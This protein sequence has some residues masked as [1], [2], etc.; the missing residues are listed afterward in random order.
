MCM[1]VWRSTFFSL[2]SFRMFSRKTKMLNTSWCYCCFLF[3]L[4]QVIIDGENI[5]GKH[6]DCC[7]YHKTIAS[8]Y[9]LDS[10]PVAVWCE[11]VGAFVSVATMTSLA[12][13]MVSL[14]SLWLTL[15]VPL[16]LSNSNAFCTQNHKQPTSDGISSQ[17]SKVLKVHIC[18][19]VNF[20]NVMT[21]LC[22]C[23]QPAECNTRA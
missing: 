19:H 13:S 17:T 6:S 14:S 23:Y 12:V 20:F 2:I 4:D 11:P 7:W 18:T 5:E 22:I 16:A 21:G 3:T 10:L 8:P 15:M 9:M 1:Y